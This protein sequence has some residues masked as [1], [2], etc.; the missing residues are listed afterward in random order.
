[1]T[2]RVQAADF[3]VGAELAALRA[4]DARV[5]ALATFRLG[6]VDL[7]A[8]L[9]EQDARTVATKF[10]KTF[11]TYLMPIDDGALALFTEWVGELEHEHHWG[12]DDP[13]FPA[14]EMGLGEDG[15]FRPAGLLRSGWSTTQ[16]INAVFRRAFEAAGLPYHNP[17]SF[18]DML[19]RHA[20][21]LSLSPETM[22]SLAQNLGHADVLTT[23]TSYGTVPVHRQG[24]LIRA[25][26]QNCDAGDV[27]DDP[28]VRAL[29][30]AI[31]AKGNGGLPGTGAGR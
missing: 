21:T 24:E 26:G 14:T 30:A 12:N 7:A 5:G 9:V 18:R 1:M 17:H 15:G 8:G 22:K 3:D 10:A 19:V 6:H 28:D 27:L 31:Q 13:L 11:R 25:I 20:M 29:I 16:P 23:F 2:V 4:G